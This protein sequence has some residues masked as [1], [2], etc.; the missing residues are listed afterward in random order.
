MKFLGREIETTVA[1]ER[2]LTL[3]RLFL[4]LS[5]L[6][7]GAALAAFGENDFNQACEL[8]GDDWFS[9]GA[10]Q[11]AKQFGHEQLSCIAGTMVKLLAENGC[12]IYDE[13][14]YA[15]E[16]MIFDVLDECAES[17]RCITAIRE[18]EEEQVDKESAR[19]ARTYRAWHM[20]IG[21]TMR[22]G[23][24]DAL[25][26]AFKAEM[27][28]VGGA[29]LSGAYNQLERK[30][31]VGK[32]Q[33]KI[34]RLFELYRA[35]IAD[36]IRRCVLDNLKGYVKCLND[37]LDYDLDDEWPQLNPRDA[38][39]LLTNLRNGAVSDDCREQAVFKLV[40]SNPF[41]VE[42]YDWLYSERIVDRK[43]IRRMAEYFAVEVPSINAEDEKSRERKERRKQKD[44]DRRV[45]EAAR[46]KEED[47]K[48]RTLFG[49]V[50]PTVAEMEFAR[51]DREEFYEGIRRLVYKHC[52]DD[53]DSFVG[54]KLDSERVEKI[55]TTFCLEEG[56][57]PI[58]ALNTP[59]FRRLAYGLVFTTHGLR[60]K[61]KDENVSRTSFLSWSEFASNEK[62]L[63]MN[64]DGQ[65]VFA[66]G[67]VLY[68][69]YAANRPERWLPV[70]NGA[71]TY[72]NEGMFGK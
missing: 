5:R 13:S 36:A 24:K 17:G 28:N 56:E 51:G 59:L 20:W 7:H 46:Q 39:A 54:S 68:L 70:L 53:G 57:Q 69:D 47:E 3:K 40:M 52:G 55:K 48:S 8:G 10:V 30:F 72:W 58:W 41:D 66:E 45:A 67:A 12:Y 23:I 16:Y 15:E 62:V 14:R 33:E 9:A 6:I 38:S 2:Y 35:E 18:I 44:R 21:G 29:L 34:Y 1:F 50:W 11:W 27:M 25:R 37:N 4:E 60:W 49:K 61:N 43:A 31:T 65:I 42:A 22:G 32:A 19:S 63:K 26:G 64:R 71:K